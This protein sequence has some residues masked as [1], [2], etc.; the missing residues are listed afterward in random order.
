MSSQPSTIDS[1]KDTA[2]S[3]YDSVA[4][5]VTS[6]QNQ[7]DYNPH[8]DPQNFDKD[9]HGNTFKKG[10]FKDQLNKAATGDLNNT[11]TPPEGI[12]DKGNAGIPRRISR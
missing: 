3:T 2:N 9:A 4:S 12:L 11:D 6:S 1:L 8:K 7:A 10:D 5:T